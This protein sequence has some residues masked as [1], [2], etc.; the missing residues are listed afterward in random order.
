M[1]VLTL[2]MLNFTTGA[3]SGDISYEDPSGLMLEDEACMVISSCY[4]LKVSFVALDCRFGEKSVK[5]RFIES[6]YVACFSMFFTL[7]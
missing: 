5:S 7:V 6:C 3:A 2:D 4:D 1:T